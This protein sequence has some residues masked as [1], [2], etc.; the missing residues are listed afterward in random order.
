MKK[1]LITI[2][3]GALVFGAIAY[4]HGISNNL[5]GGGITTGEDT[6][7]VSN[8]AT[9]SATILSVNTSRTYAKCT[10]RSTV[11]RRL[12]VMFSTTASRNF[13]FPVWASQSFEITA[14]ND[15]IVYAGPVTATIFSEVGSTTAGWGRVNCV[16]R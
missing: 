16:E 9:V 6:E 11:G 2:F 8:V 7:T 12:D 3:V 14:D 5:G 10:N 4:F 15:G 1:V 13:G